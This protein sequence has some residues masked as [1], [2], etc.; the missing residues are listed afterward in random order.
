MDLL[1]HVLAF[2]DAK[3][4]LYCLTLTQ[5]MRVLFVPPHV[6]AARPATLPA[7]A[8]GAVARPSGDSLSGMH[9]VVRPRVQA[10]WKALCARESGDGKGGPKGLHVAAEL[11]LL[12]GGDDWFLNYQKKH[13][14]VTVVTFK[15]ATRIQAVYRGHA[16]RNNLQRRKQPG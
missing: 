15:Q 10:L 8:A 5:T 4:L 3:S 16:E 2:L 12:D 1:F 6:E 14:S 13:S 11:K 7:S 9:Q